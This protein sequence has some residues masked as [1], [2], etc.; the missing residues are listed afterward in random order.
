MSRIPI[1]LALSLIMMLT[2]TAIAA[3]L[4]NGAEAS[5]AY[6]PPICLDEVNQHVN[7]ATEAIDNADMAEAKAQLDIVKGLLDQLKDITSN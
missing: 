5:Q 2:I 4:S 3:N 7:D 1:I 6:C